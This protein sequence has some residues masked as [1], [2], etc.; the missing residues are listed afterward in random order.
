MEKQVLSIRLSP[1]CYS[2]LKSE[3][4]RGNIGEFVEKI[5]LKELGEKGR[6]LEKEYLECYSNPRM[7][8]EAKLW[9]KAEIKSWLNYERDRKR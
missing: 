6:E 9:E 7:K 8:K 2:L 4:G 3:I 5:V 1:Y